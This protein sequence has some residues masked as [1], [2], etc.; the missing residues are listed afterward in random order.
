MRDANVQPKTGGERTE[1]LRRMTQ[2][3]AR[4]AMV[5]GGLEPVT[6][7]GAGGHS[8]F[9]N[10][11]LGALSENDELLEAAGL[12]QRLRQKVVLNAEQTP[13]YADICLADH[14]GGDFIFVPKGTVV[15]AAA[16]APTGAG[17]TRAPSRPAAAPAPVLRVPLPGDVGATFRDCAECPEMV[18]VPAGKFTMGGPKRPNQSATFEAPER[19]VTIDKRLAIGRCEVTRSEYAAFVA[20]TKRPV[21]G[22]CKRYVR[23]EYASNESMHWRNPGYEQEADEPAACIAWESAKAYVA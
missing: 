23:P 8:V 7:Q 13:Q 11:F 15:A 20:A 21:A 14:E 1:W 5:S 16:P 17:E 19:E 9:A 4:T 6:D 22:G 18:V 2:R 10:A 3:R 12:F